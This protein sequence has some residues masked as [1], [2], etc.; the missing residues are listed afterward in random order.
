MIEGHWRK[1][2]LLSAMAAGSTAV[3]GG[4]S[5]APP[6][7]HVY[8]RAAVGIPNKDRFGANHAGAVDVYLSDGTHQLLNELNLGVVNEDDADPASFGSAVAITDLD[9]DGYSDLVIGAPILPF[10]VDASFLAGHVDLAFGTST[11]LT[12]ARAVRLDSPGDKGDRFGAAV[13]VTGRNIE[14]GPLD[15]WV[16][17]PGADVDG[18][19]DAGAVY[20]YAVDTEGSATLVSKITQ[21]TPGVGGTAEQD[22]RFGEVLAP[23]SLGVVIGV[24]HEDVG[25]AKDAGGVQILT[26]NDAGTLTGTSLDYTQDTPGVPGTAEAGDRFGAAL[27]Y[28]G[29]AIGVPGEDVGKAKDAG[30]VQLMFGEDHPIGQALTQNSKGIPGT[31]EAG[32]EFGASLTGV[33]TCLDF[34]SI[35]IGAP[36]E[37]IGAATGAGSVTI[38]PAPSEKF[39]ED[40]PATTFAQGHGAPGVSEKGDRFGTALAAGSRD[41][42]PSDPENFGTGKPFVGVPGE[43]IGTRDAGSNTGRAVQGSR[44]YGYPGGDTQNLAYGS[45]LATPMYT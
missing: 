38:V 39:P 32:D 42:S 23:S 8:I 9:H 36:G 30:L 41:P 21:N 19:T 14:N 17:A 35:A 20:H 31:A 26:V 2:V 11:G 13:A 34:G 10:G 24:P 33:S 16:G 1:L 44:S 12:A 4:A 3:A 28:G 29:T 37:G 5:A 27:A 7:D 40:C 43:D 22:D 18:V 25:A 45:V 15:L 6:V